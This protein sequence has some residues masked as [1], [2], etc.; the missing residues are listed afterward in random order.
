MRYA[1]VRIHFVAV[2]RIVVR[3]RDVQS[4]NVFP[5]VRIPSVKREIYACATVRCHYC[6][7]GVMFSR[8]LK[9]SESFR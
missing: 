6:R 2:R 4:V 5:T 7:G 3:T 8:T 1:N 9:Q